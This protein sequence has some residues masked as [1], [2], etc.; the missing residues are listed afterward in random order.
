MSA[1]DRVGDKNE[2]KL[3]VI[4]SGYGEK[5][6]QTCNMSIEL[7]NDGNSSANVQDLNSN[8]VSLKYKFLFS[9]HSLRP[10]TEKREID[11]KGENPDATGFHETNHSPC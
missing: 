7:D 10:K 5:S 2:L 1:R 4:G 3:E 8:H 9:S 11:E 6:R